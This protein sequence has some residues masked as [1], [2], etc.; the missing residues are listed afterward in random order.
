M[1]VPAA[2]L[3]LALH[4]R[5]RERAPAGAWLRHLARWS[6]AVVLCCAAGVSAQVAT[7]APAAAPPSTPT[8]TAPPPSAD[9]ARAAHLH[10]FAGFVEWPAA[11][12]SAPD[13]PIIVGIVGAPGL[14][15]E[16][17]MLVAGRL[18]Q[19]RALH[20]VELAEPRQGRGVH[21]LVLGRAAKRAGEWTA[22]AKGQPV[23]VVTDFARGLERGAALAFVEVDGQLRFEAS[24][25]AADAAG[26]RLSSRLLALAERVVK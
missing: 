16:L 17:S 20:V 6:H 23:L 1:T 12:F 15:K 11:S 5:Y 13:A 21:M 24:V 9:E 19:N 25:P 18:V 14:H 2:A 8:P 7:P 26:L 10:R 4:R 22:A 3:G